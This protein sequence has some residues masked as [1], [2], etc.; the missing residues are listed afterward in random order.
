MDRRLANRLIS[1]A[2]AF[3]VTSSLATGI[4]SLAA[5]EAA[6]AAAQVVQGGAMSICPRV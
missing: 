5:S 1:L 3:V 2:L 4:H 6:S